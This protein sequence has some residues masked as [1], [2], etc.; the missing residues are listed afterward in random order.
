[1]GSE[2]HGILIVETCLI[3]K[4]QSNLVRNLKGQIPAATE[5]ANE[6][7]EEEQQG[8]GLI[9]PRKPCLA[10]QS[11]DPLPAMPGIRQSCPSRG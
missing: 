11:A 7:S 5:K 2:F 1:M 4:R 6:R 10:E 3:V 8:I 9:T